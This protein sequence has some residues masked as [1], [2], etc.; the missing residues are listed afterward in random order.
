M[1]WRTGKNR[2]KTAGERPAFAR[3]A[4]WNASI[5]ASH[6]EYGVIH[7]KSSRIPPDKEL[8]PSLVQ[9]RILTLAPVSE[10]RVHGRKKFDAH[11][12]VAYLWALGIG[13]TRTA[14]P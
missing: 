4:Y 5:M 13:G 2:I 14:C 6:A 1:R 11:S 12:D 8:R 9:V 10:H 7:V 3:V